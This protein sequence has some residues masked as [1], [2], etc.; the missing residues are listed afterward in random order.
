MSTRSIPTN[1]IISMAFENAKY[2]TK[3]SR[4]NNKWITYLKKNKLFDKY[5]VYLANFNALGIEPKT[6]KQLSNICYNISC[7]SFRFGKYDEKDK[8]VDVDWVKTFRKFSKESIKWY[9]VKD[10][11]L[12]L[13]NGGYF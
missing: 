1:K 10:K 7:M 2:S 5:M 3:K 9:N 11:F 6:Y 13:V 4:V 12:Y 8:I